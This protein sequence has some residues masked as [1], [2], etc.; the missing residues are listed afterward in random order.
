VKEI[1][2]HQT[3]ALVIAGRVLDQYFPTVEHL[4]ALRRMALA[5]AAVRVVVAGDETY[6]GA[7]SAPG[8]K[9]YNRLAIGIVIASVTADEPPLGPLAI[10]D[11]HDGLARVRSVGDLFWR[12]AARIL[13]SLCPPFSAAGSRTALHDPSCA[14]PDLIRAFEGVAFDG[15]DLAT[16]PDGVHLVA[17]GPLAQARLACG[18]LGQ[19]RGEGEGWVYGQGSDQARASYGVFGERVAIT[20]DLGTFMLDLDSLSARTDD[21]FLIARYD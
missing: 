18:R 12:H 11:I 5:H 8:D 2:P 17:T 14:R 10:G 4:G 21:L 1:V 20:S 3:T 7:P 15:P 16:T 6:R 13:G 19:V 9:L